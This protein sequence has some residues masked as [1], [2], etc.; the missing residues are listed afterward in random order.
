VALHTQTWLTEAA[1][2]AFTEVVHMEH[3]HM[4]VPMALLGRRQLRPELMTQSGRKITPTPRSLS[5]AEPRLLEE[6]SVPMPTPMATLQ[7]QA[8]RASRAALLDLVREPTRDMLPCRHTIPLR[9][10]LVKTK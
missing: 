5:K 7:T 4:L 1:Q 8:S 2:Q 3:P 10:I 6:L 9:S